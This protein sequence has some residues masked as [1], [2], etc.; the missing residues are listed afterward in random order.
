MYAYFTPI[1]DEIDVPI[2]IPIKAGIKMYPKVYGWITVV[3]SIL[4]SKYPKVPIRATTKVVADERAAAFLKGIWNPINT[5]TAII[6]P[7]IPKSADRKPIDD[8]VRIFLANVN[9]PKCRSGKWG[10]IK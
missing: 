7:P 8:E 1:G 6:P 2:E 9:L 10:T 3:I 4:K 5:G